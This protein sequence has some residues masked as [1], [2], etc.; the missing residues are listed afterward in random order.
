MDVYS[1]CMHASNSHYEVLAIVIPP[2]LVENMS[3]SA[4]SNLSCGLFTCCLS[5]EEITKL[6]A[7]RRAEL[8]RFG[9]HASRSTAEAR[10]NLTLLGTEFFAFA[11]ESMSSALVEKGAEPLID[12][13]K[14]IFT[15]KMVRPMWRT[16][17]IKVWFFEINDMA[18]AAMRLIEDNETANRKFLFHNV[19]VR[20]EKQRNGTTGIV[21]SNIK[22]GDTWAC[23]DLDLETAVDVENNDDLSLRE[24]IQKRVPWID[25]PLTEIHMNASTAKK[26]IE[27]SPPPPCSIPF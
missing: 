3:A 2:R 23:W 16:E 11:Y 1:K 15:V 20:M 9:T 25:G 4:S 26:L 21:L 24:D 17:M 19:G 12:R 22:T 27:F 14:G 5:T 8:F 18:Y 10:F 6:K 13:N 7:Q